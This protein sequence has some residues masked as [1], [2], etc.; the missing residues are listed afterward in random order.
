ML[1][2][3][4]GKTFRRDEFVLVTKAGLG[5]SGPDASRR[6]LLDTLNTSLARLDTDH[7]DLWQLEAVDPLTPLEET[8][9]VLEHAVTSGRARYV[10]VTDH[11]GWQLARAATLLEASSSRARLVA[12]GV[13]YSLLERRAE[14]EV[15]PAAASCGLGVLAHA[16][17]AGGVLTGKYRHNTPLDSRAARTD[18]L[19]ERLGPAGRAVVD[20]LA[21]A[22]TGLG[23]SPAEVALA[24]VRDR[25]GVSA[26]I[27]GAR[28]TAQL[29]TALAAE[30]LLLPSEIRAALD[31]ISR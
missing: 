13:E 1:G 24:W 2:S 28:N 15:L 26:A 23:V 14:V 22:A 6:A 5:A 31:D 16:P 29:A 17:L 10:G 27:V 11:R 3:L 30:S 18:D 12:G 25:P 21:T 19:D 7:V 9:A 20:A 4:L 8:L